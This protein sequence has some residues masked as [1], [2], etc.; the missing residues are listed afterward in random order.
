MKKLSKW[1]GN[2]PFYFVLNPVFGGITDDKANNFE[3]T[4][5]RQT[6][7]M[8]FV[9]VLELCIEY[10]MIKCYNNYCIGRYTQGMAQSIYLNRKGS[11]GDGKYR[12]FNFS[13]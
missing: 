13:C 5:K 12:C 2:I 8:M 6:P 4:T 11:I 7:K 1:I 10:S 3:N 9:Y